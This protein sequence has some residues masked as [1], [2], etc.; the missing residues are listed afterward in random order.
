MLCE[1]E[2]KR[3]S[4]LDSYLDW[5]D[6]KSTITNEVCIDVISMEKITNIINDKSYKVFESKLS[7]FKNYIDKEAPSYLDQCIQRSSLKYS[8]CVSRNWTSVVNILFNKWIKK[9][10]NALFTNHRKLIFSRIKDFDQ[11]IITREI[12]SEK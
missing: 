1:E 6:I 5:K 7:D 11:K 8:S 4:K 9:P 12:A 10:K 3:L 2:I